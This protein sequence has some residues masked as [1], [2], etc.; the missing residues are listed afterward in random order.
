MD[1]AFSKNGQYVSEVY[2]S[3]ENINII[4]TEVDYINEGIVKFKFDTAY[5]TKN[6]TTEQSFKGDCSLLFTKNLNLTGMPNGFISAND[7]VKQLNSLKNNSL[8]ET[9]S[10]IDY[11]LDC[12]TILQNGLS[13]I[14]FKGANPKDIPSGL[15]R[16]YDLIDL[17]GRFN[18][19]SVIYEVE[20]TNEPSLFN[21]FSIRKNLKT[22]SFN[23]LK[24][25]YNIVVWNKPLFASL[26]DLIIRSGL[27]QSKVRVASKG[28]HTINT[29]DINY[30]KWSEVKSEFLEMD[31]SDDKFIH[32]IST[33]YKG[34]FDQ[35]SL[36]NIH[37]E[38]RSIRPEFKKLIELAT[39]DLINRMVAT[40]KVS[41]LKKGA[42]FLI[43]KINYNH[44]FS[45]VFAER[46]IGEVECITS[47]WLKLW[48]LKVIC[49]E[50][51]NINI[52]SQKFSKNIDMKIKDN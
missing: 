42:E 45:S 25:N 44:E 18:V 13:L 35:I 50:L 17:P 4:S 23:L 20:E 22:F 39:K 40:E 41:N 3:D 8:K 5:S 31:Y 6:C 7:M 21:P 15:V 32:L 29:E 1:S 51:A 19:S 38:A 11:R 33:N 46:I 34:I 47:P 27:S 43:G 37:E 52:N 49:E 48:F 14:K 16:I 12:N 36:N 28:D 24:E 10:A 26:F 2:L 9:V 30:T